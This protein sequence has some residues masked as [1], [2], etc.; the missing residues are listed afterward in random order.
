MTYRI[1]AS[2]TR[3]GEV[4]MYHNTPNYHEAQ[5]LLESYSAYEGVTAKLEKVVL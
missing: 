5:Q 2:V 4:F 3:T 1:T